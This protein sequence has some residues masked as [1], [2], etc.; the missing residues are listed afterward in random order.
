VLIEG[1][2][3]AVSSKGLICVQAFAS[4]TIIVRKAK[5]EIF[6]RLAPIPA[7]RAARKVAPMTFLMLF[8]MLFDVF[9]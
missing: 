6:R 5:K 2:T 8:I 3:A 9:Q 1:Q 7:G 4:S